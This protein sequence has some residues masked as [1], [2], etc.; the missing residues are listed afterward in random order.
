MQLLWINVFTNIVA[1]VAIA[2]APPV[3]SL[4]LTNP[5]KINDR[6]L[7]PVMLVEIFFLTA[8]QIS[9]LLCLLLLSD[10]FLGLPYEWCTPTWVT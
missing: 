6:M 3:E 1:V 5:Y 8:Y 9:A 4:L 10:E 7:T 2:S